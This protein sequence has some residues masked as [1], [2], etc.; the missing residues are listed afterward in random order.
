MP[1]SCTV[2]HGS[3]WRILS[4]LHPLA[5]KQKHYI[6]PISEV[7]LAKNQA[8]QCLSS[9]LNFISVTYFFYGFMSPAEEQ[10][11]FG[12]ESRGMG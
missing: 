11:S 4:Q 12:S 5:I 10:M 9:S 2:E 7:T 6:Y 8:A 1:L 3:T